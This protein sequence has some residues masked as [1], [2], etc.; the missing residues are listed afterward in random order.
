[1][2]FPDLVEKVAK[3][4]PLTSQE[5]QVPAPE[6]VGFFVRWVRTLHG[7]KQ[8]TLAEFAGVSLSTVERVERG[9]QVSPDLL[10][11][12]AIGLGY[13]AGYF[14]KPRT[15]K[16]VE[17]AAAELDEKFGNM[18][19][20]QVAPLRKQSQ[21]RKLGDCHAFLP[22][23]VK[24]S[25]AAEADIM[26]LI[27]WFDLLSF[28][29]SEIGSADFDKERRKRELY[30]DILADVRRIER[31]GITVLAGVMDAPQ[32]GIPDWKVAILSFCS[33][34]DDPGALKRKLIF[35]DKRSVDIRNGCELFPWQRE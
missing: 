7:W 1:M 14:T 26:N 10:D 33:K 30:N 19:P 13:D 28:L 6:V 8:S 15:P 3:M 17:E 35:V 16:S 31:S 24:T 9:E 20:V 4:L 12:I 23:R 2:S 32:E 25:D 29:K 18:M 22:H 5:P 21:V 27:E 11:R 34:E